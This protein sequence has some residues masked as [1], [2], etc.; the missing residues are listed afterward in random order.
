MIESKMLWDPYVLIKNDNIKDFWATILKKNEKSIFIL[1]K[2]FDPRMNTFFDLIYDDIGSNVNYSILNIEGDLGPHASLTKQN[3]EELEN[4]LIAKNISYMVHSVEMWK[5]KRNSKTRVGPTNVNNLI[6]GEFLNGYKNIIVDISSMPRV[7]YLSLITTILDYTRKKNKNGTIINV[8]VNVVESPLIDN[9]ISSSGVDD[10]A[11]FVP[12]LGGD[13]MIESDLTDLSGNKKPKIWIPILGEGQEYKLRKI[14]EIVLPKIICP[15]LPFPSVKPR[16]A[17]DLVLEYREVLFDIW[18]VEQENIIYTSENNPFE[19]YRH[20]MK[21]INRY[22][23][24]LEPIGECKIAL[25]SLSS[26]LISIGVLLT[27]YEMYRV[28]EKS[29]GLI[30]VGGSEYNYDDKILEKHSNEYENLIT[31][32]IDGEPYK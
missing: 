30:H 7:I 1:A 9:L 26:K 27:T 24:A 22:F 5:Q 32:W 4:K 17:D 3:W 29:V 2:G 31:L 6:G 23:D 15:V 25:S 14:E 16:R 18:L 12:K 10:K 20:L 8:F 13:F 28:K 11:E 19:L 21:T